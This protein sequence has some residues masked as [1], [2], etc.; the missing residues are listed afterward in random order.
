MRF[1]QHVDDTSR[2]CHPCQSGLFRNVQF[3]MRVGMVFRGPRKRFEIFRWD[4]SR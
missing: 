4:F 2:V 1:T 3:S